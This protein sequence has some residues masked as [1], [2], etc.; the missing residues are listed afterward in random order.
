VVEIERLKGEGAIFSLFQ[1]PSRPVTD[2]RARFGVGSGVGSGSDTLD[3][4]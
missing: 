3:G 4:G 1:S 2:T